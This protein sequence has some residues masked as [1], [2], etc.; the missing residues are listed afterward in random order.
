M[1]GI[2]ASQAPLVSAKEGLGINDLLEAVVQ[3]IP[4]PEGDEHGK[5]KAL[6]F[7]SVYDLSLIHI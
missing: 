5:L 4:A 1:I 6:I 2:D 3:T 7:D